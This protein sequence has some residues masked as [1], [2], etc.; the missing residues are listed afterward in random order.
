MSE[1][2]VDERTL[3]LAFATVQNFLAEVVEIIGAH[4]QLR[5][6]GRVKVR[7]GGREGGKEEWREGGMEGGRN[8]GR[9]GGREKG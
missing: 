9:E 2:V 3:D 4:Q 8:G 1:P 7:R 6:E 5:E